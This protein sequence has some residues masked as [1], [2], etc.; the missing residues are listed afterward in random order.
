MG[1]TYMYEDFR[2][3]E[4]GYN[5]GTFYKTKHCIPLLFNA[6]PDRDFRN[7]VLTCTDLLMHVAGAYVFETS[8]PLGGESQGTQK[9]SHMGVDDKI[10]TTPT[11]YNVGHRIREA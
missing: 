1:L 3:V 10:K 5:T 9:L 11:V 2:L 8:T 7:K 4:S 6:M